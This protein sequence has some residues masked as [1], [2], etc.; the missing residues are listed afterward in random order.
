M[1]VVSIVLQ[2]CMIYFYFIYYN[3]I[4]LLKEIWEGE[5]EGIEKPLEREMSVGDL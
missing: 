5:Y 1:R 3:K 4:F 2:S